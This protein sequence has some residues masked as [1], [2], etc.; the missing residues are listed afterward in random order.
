MAGEDTRPPPQERNDQRS[1]D[2]N[3]E[4]TQGQA[5]RTNRS[6]QLNPQDEAYRRSRGGGPVVGG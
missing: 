5:A 1:R 6:R 4:G 3:P 2:L